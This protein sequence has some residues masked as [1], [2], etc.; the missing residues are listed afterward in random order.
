[1]KKDLKLRKCPKCKAQRLEVSRTVSLMP[2]GYEETEAKL[3]GACGYAR[4]KV[5]SL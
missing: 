1:M 4:K 2:H 3:C 5:N